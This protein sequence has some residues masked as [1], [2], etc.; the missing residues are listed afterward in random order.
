MNLKLTRNDDLID[1]VFGELKSLDSKLSLLTLEH[2]Y[3]KNGGWEPK[4]PVGLYQCKRGMHRL[5]SMTTDFETFEITGVPGHTNILFHCG[6]MALQFLG[7]YGPTAHIVAVILSVLAGLPLVVSSL[8]GVWHGLALIFP[9]LKASQA[10]LD[11]KSSS[12]LN[13]LDRLSAIKPPTV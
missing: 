4:V 1:G 13:V 10:A 12:V 6:N 2:S 9:G 11:S 5:H 3:E 8:I 7:N